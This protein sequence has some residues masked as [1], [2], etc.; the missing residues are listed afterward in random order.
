[1]HTLSFTFP[2]SM[3]LP[4]PVHVGVV[5]SGDLEILAVPAPDSEVATVQVRTS[6]DGFDAIWERVLGRFFEA[7]PIRA[8]V[9]INDFGA[10]PG[11]VSLRLAHALELAREG[12][13]A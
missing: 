3:P 2:A 11:M 6:V 7:S 9:D 5:A 13:P 10:T 1:M 12:G 4:S 8:R